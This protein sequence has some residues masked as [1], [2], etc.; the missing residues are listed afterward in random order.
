MTI[1]QLIIMLNFNKI[2]KKVNQIL[3]ILMKPKIILIINQQLINNML[4]E[5][6]YA[7]V[8][9]NVKKKMLVIIN[10]LS[11]NY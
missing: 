11:K 4:L 7:K 1:N 10:L 8:L 9:K 3:I 5:D 2:I 6:N